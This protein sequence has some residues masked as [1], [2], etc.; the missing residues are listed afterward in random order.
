VKAS[1]KLGKEFDIIPLTFVLPKE[2][3]AFS[4]SFL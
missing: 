3:A 4:E 2:Y 1:A